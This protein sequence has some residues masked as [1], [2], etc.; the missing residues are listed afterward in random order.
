MSH[1]L[2]AERLFANLCGRHFL[3]GFVFHSPKFYDPTEKEAGDVVIW[4]RRQVIVVEMLARN[5]ESGV[6]TKQYVKRIGEKRNQLLNDHAAFTDPEVKIHLV[7]EYGERV[8]FDTR[9]LDEVVFSGII[10]LDC[11]DPLEKPHYSSLEKSLS[12]PFP[13]AVMTRQD[14]LDLMSEVDTIP[15]LSY[16][17]ADRA[18]FLKTV[19]SQDPRPFLDLNGGLEKNLIA[20]YKLNEN[21]FPISQWDPTEA[22]K[23]YHYYRSSL[24]KKIEARDAENSHSKIIDSM[25]D[26]LRSSNKPDDSTLLHSWELASLTRRQRAGPMS[27][28]IVDAIERMHGGNARR[29]FAFFNQATGCWLVFFFQYGGDRESFRK[30]ARALT[31]YKLIVEMRRHDFD[32]SVFGYAFRKSALHSESTFEEIVLSIEDASNYDLVSESEYQ[33]ALQFFGARDEI[34]IREFP[35]SHAV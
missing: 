25:I 35:D 23:Y 14:F 9:D 20:F 31:R 21:H 10:L 4:V 8:E 18:A 26:V 2:K 7:N 34:K 29:H 19:Y 28:K 6:S 3:R 33:D 16:Y 30:H 15:D 11:N 1:G 17:L 5:A 24:Q 32:Y 13:I 27:S 12:V 22:F